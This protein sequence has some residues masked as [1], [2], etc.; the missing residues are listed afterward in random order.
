MASTSGSISNGVVATSPP[1]GSKRG[2]LP[3]HTYIATLFSL[4]ILGAGSVIGW[5]NYVQNRQLIISASQELIQA[6]GGK[7]VA[8]FGAIYQPVELLVD[9]LAHQR[10]GQATNL[11]DRM[12][13]VTYIADA[14]EHS[15]SLSALYVGY[16]NGDFFLLRPLRDHAAIRAQF[17]APAD[18]A[19]LVQSIERGPAGAPRGTYIFLDSGLT[20]LERREV[21]DYVF[22]PRT[23]GWYQQALAS[24]Q[25]VKTAPYVFFSTGEA[26]LTFARRSDDG[27][28]AVG[29]DLTL[30]DLSLA[31]QQQK[32]TP[33][34]ELVLFNAD[35]VALG[36]DKPE[37]MA[38]DRGDRSNPRLASVSE[39]GSP[40][41]SRLMETV[42]TGAATDMLALDVSGRQWAGMVSKLQVHGEPSGVYLA[43]LS[44]EDELLSE[45]RRISRETLMITLAI[46]LLSLPVVWLLARLVAKPLRSLAREARAVREF[47]FAAPIAT[48][49]V[50]AE[51][52]EL[53]GTMD[54][55][56]ITIRKF[57]DIAATISAE[58]NFQR[59]LERVLTET[60]SA[61]GSSAGAIY[62]L[63]D[64]E[65]TLKAVAMR[66][67]S[68]AAS[69]PITALGPPGDDHPA[70]R[71]VAGGKTVVASLGPGY[72]DLTRLAGPTNS[73]SGAEAHVA[74]AVPLRNR[75]AVI[76]GVIYLVNDAATG[77]LPRELVSFVEAL[78]GTAAI[79][80]ENQDLLRAQKEVLECFIKLVAG[81]IDAKSPYTGGHCQRVPELATMLARAACD[82]KHGPFRDFA[83]SDDEWEA[84]RIAAWLHDC[85]KVTTPEYIVDKATKL[86]TIY[87][88]LH[89]VRMRFE[90]L[91]RDAEIEYWQQI[92]AGGDRASLRR[93]F[94]AR[95]GELDA[96]FSFVAS[97]NEGGE[98]TEPEKI[99]R[100]KEIARRTWVR[101]LD[102]RIGLSREE[103]MRAAE[104]PAPRLPVVEQLLADKPEHRIEWSAG[105]RVPDDNRWGFQVRVPSH[106]RNNGEIYN[107]CIGR[108]TLTD[109]ERHAIND[110]VVQTIK[111]L[112][113]LP[114]PKHLKRVP[115][116]AGGHHERL[117]GTGYPKRLRGEELSLLARMMAI[118]DIFEALTARDRP[119]KKGKTLSEAIRIMASMCGEHHIDGD[120]FELF[121]TSGVYHR[122]AEVFLH[123]SQI[124]EVDI[125]A[126]VA[127][128][129]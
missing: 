39:L 35:G 122:Y 69:P 94:D 78:S 53:A 108:G 116:I 36:Y 67:R 18:A 16:G 120:L 90:V 101:T 34:S 56:K 44:P 3:L 25:Q 66:A 83:M 55:M 59:L 11:A 24:Q 87:D 10:L 91:K 60:I 72:D 115:E 75:D 88:R 14:L 110:H 28:S 79:S 117:D 52:D 43:V 104:M 41:L 19:Y 31:L 13:S 62:L 37:R 93:Q 8:A 99:A 113:G 7:A 81:A 112:S 64:S 86:Q 47:D 29:A 33:S 49:S 30:R 68:G 2:R 95:C 50:V 51:V 124:D 109:E 125:A 74:I 82:A 65:R 40:G 129:A 127:H 46:L 114:F 102:D 12:E 100:I 58:H 4:L 105:D 89:E 119:Y 38:L 71:A 80:I 84:L 96:E 9:L 57:L 106:K 77:T 111:M 107:L 97:C 128:A 103:R 6:I 15:P 63:D 118:A 61:T 126:H 23:R 54:A 45:A 21:P 42:G 121:L 22:D 17:G 27:A 98:F 48:R 123:P 76:I 92:A 32:L 73:R 85:G 26:G 20:P 70:R 5:H 1:P